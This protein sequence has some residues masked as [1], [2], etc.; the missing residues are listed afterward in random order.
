[1]AHTSTAMERSV[2]DSSQSTDDIYTD[3]STSG[4]GVVINNR[5]YSGKWSATHYPR[6]INFK[7]LLTVFYALQRPKVKGRT[8]NIIS[9]NITTASLV[10]DNPREQRKQERYS[11]IQERYISWVKNRGF[12]PQ[13]PNPSQLLNWL[14]A[15]VLVKS[16]QAST[17]NNYKAA[18]IYMHEDKSPFLDPDF[19]S[20]FRNGR[21]R[22]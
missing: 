11:N 19:L 7:E 14:T 9:D 15:G 17:V 6:H 10:L 21:S 20:Y 22:I 12:D 16:W 3:A 5:S 18:I 2:M 13:Q 1:M 8:V 4:W